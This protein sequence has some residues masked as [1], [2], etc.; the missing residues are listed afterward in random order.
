MGTAQL[1]HVLIAVGSCGERRSLFLSTFNIFLDPTELSRLQKQ[2]SFDSPP[3]LNI[4]SNQDTSSS[5]VARRSE[6]PASF[7]KPEMTEKKECVK[8]YP[9]N[10]RIKSTVSLHF[11]SGRNKQSVVPDDEYLI[12]K[13]CHR[14]VDGKVSDAATLSQHLLDG[15]PSLS[16]VQVKVK[17]WTT[18]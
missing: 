18:H 16:A 6:S 2:F 8:F 11:G 14:K 5:V 10:K 3:V 17:D 15:Q 13:E 1:L 7:R 4:H 12:C 9:S